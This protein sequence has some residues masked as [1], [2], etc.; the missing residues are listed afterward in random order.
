MESLEQT[1]Q[2]YHREL[3]AEMARTLGMGEVPARKREIIRWLVQEI[4][5]RAEAGELTAGLDEAQQAL[6]GLLLQRGGEMDYVEAVWHLALLGLTYPPALAP[7][8]APPAA[9]PVHTILRPLLLRGLVVVPEVEWSGYA[10]AFLGLDEAMNG[11]L[12]R[13]LS[14]APEVLAALRRAGLTFPPPPFSI[15]PWF[16]PP[17]AHPEPCRDPHPFLRNA[18]LL[19]ESLRLHPARCTREGRL[20]KHESRRLLKRLGT[21]GDEAW[22]AETFHLLREL[23]LVSIEARQTRVGE[24]AERFWRDSEQA[25]LL[26]FFHRFRNDPALYSTL[27][28]EAQRGLAYEFDTE[29][30]VRSALQLR[31]SLLK[32]LSYVPAGQWVRIELLHCLLSQGRSGGYL[33]GGD[34]LLRRK[35]YEWGS[36]YLDALSSRIAEWELEILHHFLRLLDALGLV[37]RGRT[38]GGAWLISPCESFHAAMEGRLAPPARQWQMVIQ[39]N[40]Q[41]MVMGEPPLGLL[42]ELGV[43][44]ELEAV[45]ERTLTYRLTQQSLYHAFR[46]GWS[47][48]RIRAFFERHSRAAMAQNLLRTMEEWWEQYQR[49]LLRRD[50]LVVQAQETALIEALL[51][52]PAVAEVAYRPREDLLVLPA[53]MES[54][55]RRL[56]EKLD[57]PPLEGEAAATERKHSLR[58]EGDRLVPTQPFP[59]LY[60]EAAVGRFAQREAEGWRLT[61]ESIR[62]AVEA[63]M[64]VAAILDELHQMLVEPLPA[65]W[66]RRIKQWG[67]HY[68]RVQVAEVYLLRFASR[69][70]LEEV[71]AEFPTLRPLLRPLP[72][73]QEALALVQV[74]DWPKV[75]ERLGSLGVAFE[76]QSWW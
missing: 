59:G 69:A 12:P 54:T 27:V 20:T 53:G 61:R 23:G 19:W 72:T 50:R 74:K 65:E 56:L 39:P 34:K 55:V 2:R 16:Q 8:P 25:V 10:R 13:R 58:L 29:V 5:A 36:R 32:A 38:E 11:D 45:Q 60:V 52:S 73:A 43:M 68:G 40:A 62:A 7:C 64:T 70:L 1:F 76:M 14:L 51:R 49:I 15:E 67:G 28:Q 42:A 37:Q 31:R 33:L 21:L 18:Y 24:E 30:Q 66:E 35:H 22:L 44:T 26:G 48:A 3:L 71:L 46:R 47:P 75:Q 63:G 4:P 9:R 57:A 41:V 6:V 17:P